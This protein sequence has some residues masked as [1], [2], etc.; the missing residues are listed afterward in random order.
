MRWGESKLPVRARTAARDP[1][2]MS[3]KW[4]LCRG[5]RRWWKPCSASRCRFGAS[6]NNAA[7]TCAAH[8]QGRK[9]SDAREVVTLREPVELAK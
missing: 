1:D 6:R 3:L 5:G 4:L 9:R 7:M 8:A 2:V